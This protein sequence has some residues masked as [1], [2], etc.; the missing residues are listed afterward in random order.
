M[1]RVLDRR[2]SEM[3]REM[4]ATHATLPSTLQ[5]GRAILRPSQRLMEVIALFRAVHGLLLGSTRR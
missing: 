2:M 3:E 1:D 4:H 5:R